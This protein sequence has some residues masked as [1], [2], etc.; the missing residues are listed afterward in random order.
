MANNSNLP[1]IQ[2][3]KYEDYARAGTWQEGFRALIETLNL[4]IPPVYD[5]LNGGV[6]Y[7]N[8]LAPQLYTAIVTGAA[9]TTFSFVNPLGIQPSAVLVGN[10]WTG[11][12]STHP[13][14][15]VQV[16]WHYSGNSIIVDNV[17]GLIAGTV[18]SLTLVVL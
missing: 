4:F 3:L 1:T 11:V 17:T 9:T 13:A 14:A 5:I 15:A 6:G 7:K 2:R 16:F 12:R 10:V 8:L 18:Y